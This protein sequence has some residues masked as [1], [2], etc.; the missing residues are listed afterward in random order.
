MDDIKISVLGMG[1]VGLA[2]AMG[3]A[4]HGFKTI[5]TATTPSKVE[6]LNKGIP[7]FYEPE[8]EEH[9]KREVERGMLVAT[10]DNVEA[11]KQSNVTFNCVGT[12]S[13]PDGSADLSAIEATTRDIANAIKDKDGY[14]VVVSKSTIVPGTTENL[15]LP[16]LEQYSGKKVGEDFGLVMNPEFLRQGQAVHDS[17]CPDRI[18]I[19]EHDSK[20]GQVIHQIYNSYKTDKDEPVPILHVEVK[21]AE[22]IKYAANSLLATKI[23]FANE[24]S[25]ICEKFNIDVYEVMKGVGLDFRVN[26]MFLNAGCGF[27]GS[28]FPK[29]VNA[30]VALAKK[31]EVE[32]PL[33]DAVLYTNELQPMHMFKLIKDTVGDL[34]G[35]VVAFLGLSFKPDTDDTRYTR[36]LP[37]IKKLYEEGATVK[38]YDPKAYYKFKPLTDLPIGYMDTLEEALL[39]ADFAVVQS[40][41]QEIRDVSPEMF[42]KHLKMPIVIDGRRSYDPKKM[43]AE[44]V[45]YKG[46]GWKNRD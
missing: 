19:G 7:P 20:A 45:T 2:S 12:P 3:Y 25:R 38:A 24:F 14:H 23:T 18:V 6:N 17:L 42:K 41:W 34:N 30:I 35:K 31:I 40:D 4:R 16:L 33:M 10:L 5:V 28:C 39:G 44:G 1:Y 15:V 37:I 11:I 13:L 27:G 43:I 32:T 8:L 26:P 22:L 36:A 21:A 46:V 29:D 9:V